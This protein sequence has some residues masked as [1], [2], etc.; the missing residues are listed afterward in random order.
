[1][2][3]QYWTAT[4]ASAARRAKPRFKAPK[5]GC[6]ASNT[7]QPKSKDGNRSKAQEWQDGDLD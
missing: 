6:S 5:Q 3:I 7:Q 4:V 1:M 2:T